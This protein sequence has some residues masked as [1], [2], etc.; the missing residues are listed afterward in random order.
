MCEILSEGPV[1]LHRLRKMFNF[2]GAELRCEV[3]GANEALAPNG[4]G[5][6]GPLKGPWW[7]P[8]AK[9]RWGSRGRSPPKP[10][11]FYKLNTIWKP[12][13]A[14]ARDHWNSILTYKNYKKSLNWTS[15]WPTGEPFLM[16]FCQM[17]KITHHSPILLRALAAVCI[18]ETNCLSTGSWRVSFLEKNSKDVVPFA[19]RAYFIV[20]MLE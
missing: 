3:S 19:L 14:L 13:W 9:P 17:V 15:P 1:H 16:N 20:W 4:R 6:R 2:G 5:S 10:E 12:F 18:F 8:G 11:G 7:G